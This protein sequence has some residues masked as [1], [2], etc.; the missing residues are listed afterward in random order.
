MYLPISRFFCLSSAII[1]SHFLVAIGSNPEEEG[2]SIVVPSPIVAT[3]QR[4][5]ATPE[6][7]E[8]RPAEAQ[9]P[10]LQHPEPQHP[11]L[12]KPTQ[13][14]APHRAPTFQSNAPFLETTPTLQTF[15][16]VESALHWESEIYESRETMQECVELDSSLEG[17]IG[18]SNL[19]FAKRNDQHA[20][21][22]VVLRF[23]S[24]CTDAEF[25]HWKLSSRDTPRAQP[26]IP[27]GPLIVELLAD[28][29]IDFVELMFDGTP[30]K[31][32]AYASASPLSY[33]LP[34]P[35]PGQHWLQARYLSGDIWSHYS[36]PI[37]FEVRLPPQPRIIAASDVDRD[38]TPLARN[39]MTSITT[40]SIRVHL[41]D[42]NRGDN[43]VAYVDGKPLPPHSHAFDDK[44]PK[45][46][47][48]DSQLCCRVFRVEGAVIPGVHKLTVRV[49]GCSGKCSITSQLSNSVVFHYYDEDIYL[50]RPG[51]GC[52]NGRP[53][54]V[55]S[56]TLDST[57]GTSETKRSTPLALIPA[58]SRVSNPAHVVPIFLQPMPSRED[59]VYTGGRLPALRFVSYRQSASSTEAEVAYLEIKKILDKTLADETLIDLLGHLNRSHESVK[60]SKNAVAD[61]QSHFRRAEKQLKDAA[62]EMNGVHD[63]VITANSERTRANTF[64]D[65]ELAG[66]DAA[67]T[68]VA[69][70]RSDLAKHYAQL[71]NEQAH[72]AEESYCQVNTAFE[73]AKSALNSALLHLTAAKDSHD[74]AQKEAEKLGA[75]RT[76]LIQAEEEAI[77]AYSKEYAF[78]K[79]NQIDYA[80]KALEELKSQKRIVEQSSE[81]VLTHAKQVKQFANG[82][83]DHERDAREEAKRASHAAE[84]AYSFTASISQSATRAA[85]LTADAA[86]NAQLAGRVKEKD[87]DVQR[88]LEEV[89][90]KAAYDTAVARLAAASAGGNE[91][92]VRRAQES[93]NAAE[94]FASHEWRKADLRIAEGTAN[95]IRS[96]AE[97]VIGPS[98]PFYFAAAAH[99]PIREFGLRGEPLDRDGIIIY[100]DMAFHFDRDGN[101]EVHFRASAPPMPATMRLQF[102]IQTRRDGPWYTVTL[103]PIEFP[104]PT[105]KGDKS[106]CS[107]SNC[108][109][110]HSTCSND[111]KDCCGEA[112]ECICKGHSEILRRCY[113]EMGQDAHI[114][115]SGSARMGF[116]VNVP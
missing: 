48:T 75:A 32:T 102:Q 87:K 95:A 31:P 63:S 82:A 45:P 30:L 101:Y 89:E 4:S 14:V 44:Y 78:R 17:G 53:G 113:G 35:A 16:P 66:G 3:T 80:N 115:R 65:A 108:G 67:R 84:R 107:G 60:D 50:L 86:K 1:A 46:V 103:S 70:K 20:A 62:L 40:H 43:I 59:V 29:P 23:S 94:A 55:C 10:A 13:S 21:P 109:G 98:S 116:G 106:N 12:Q 19:S 11:A 36:N 105:A 58:E 49:V 99:F 85:Q 110:G 111:S 64:A 26:A 22:E 25:V 5:S 68:Q 96:R 61:A 33:S 39:S 47:E 54:Q 28:K 93:A 8:A 41:A 9:H 56:P 76:A 81:A 100:E 69:R 42:V 7:L 79:Q 77:R 71:A 6:E 74:S 57:S 27:H 52:N 34:C 88:S 37:R 15:S 72:V 104:Y 18:N 38:P 91:N 90:E 51:A 112:R 114:R 97:K 73:N 2:D 83:A 24:G 92:G